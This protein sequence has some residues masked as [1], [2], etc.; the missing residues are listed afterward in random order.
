MRVDP[1]I[2]VLAVVIVA[3]I[4]GA[5]LLGRAVR[6][7]VA[8]AGADYARRTAETKTGTIL[9]ALGRS[10]VLDAPYSLARE[11]VHRVS[12]E[13]P[14]LFTALGNGAYGIRFVEADDAVVRLVPDEAGTRMQVERSTERLGMPQS[15]PH[16]AT[17]CARVTADAEAHGV[18]VSEGPAGGFHRIGG[19]P[20]YWVRNADQP[21][22]THS[23]R[24]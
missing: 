12:G 3:V 4:V 11:I 1:L 24:G 22:A 18:A 6:G 21:S 15:A 14:R 13:D 20:V 17:L 23:D 16:W 8:R 5:V 2:V 10:L 9:D 7:G 19:E